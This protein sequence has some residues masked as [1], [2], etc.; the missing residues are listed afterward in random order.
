MVPLPVSG[1][2]L[3]WAFRLID[4]VMAPLY[5]RWLGRDVP[6]L[7]L[8]TTLAIVFGVGGAGDQRVRPTSNTAERD[9]SV[10]GGHRHDERGPKAA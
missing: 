3:V 4:G 1:A 10:P 5:S 8:V 6:G 2:A 7:G 9:V